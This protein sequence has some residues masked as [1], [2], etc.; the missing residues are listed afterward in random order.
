[1][2]KI[3]ISL[4][5]LIT[6]SLFCGEPSDNRTAQKLE[7]TFFIELNLKGNM[8]HIGTCPIYDKR[9]QKSY[10][11]LKVDWPTQ[12]GQRLL[13]I[14]TSVPIVSNW[15]QLPHRR[16][17]INDLIDNGVNPE[18]GT[19]EFFLPRVM[20]YNFLKKLKDNDFVT[21]ET[22]KAKIT[23]KLNDESKKKLEEFIVEHNNRQTIKIT[24]IPLPKNSFSFRRLA[25]FCIFPI[26]VIG[27]STWWYFN[28]Q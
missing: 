10:E 23:F 13:P 6:Y 26:S 15:K 28:R 16:L 1:M 21:H 11:L 25:L 8:D 5:L 27:I 18:D 12:E 19:R 2:K 14:Y 20:P 24:P 17:C 4:S 3:F 7:M 9:D 22:N